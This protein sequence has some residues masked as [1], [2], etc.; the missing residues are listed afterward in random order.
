MI[1]EMLMWLFWLK[2][3][4]FKSL[5]L[6]F[7]N[8][9]QPMMVSFN[10]LISFILL[11]INLFWFKIRCTACSFGLIWKTSEIFRFI[12][13][14]SWNWFGKLLWGDY[15]LIVCIEFI[16]ELKLGWWMVYWVWLRRELN[17]KI[18]FWIGVDCVWWVFVLF[19]GVISM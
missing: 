15:C 4:K 8:W 18:I 2:K 19:I 17:L 5:N 12:S 9:I 3:W 13:W 6:I 16:F 10:C 11:I 7:Q 14:W 1:L